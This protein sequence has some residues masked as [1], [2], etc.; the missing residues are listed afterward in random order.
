MDNCYNK[1][2]RIPRELM[3]NQDERL[4]NKH[5]QTLSFLQ[6]LAAEN[7]ALKQRVEEL[8]KEQEK[9]QELHA[10]AEESQNRIK[11]IQE[12]YLKRADDINQ[13]LSEQHRME[14]M[15]LLDDKMEMERELKEQILKLRHEIESL[16]R[17][18]VQLREEPDGDEEKQSFL[19]TITDLEKK[20]GECQSKVASL[21]AAR[22]E[23]QQA[24]SSAQNSQMSELHQVQDL[25]NTNQSLTDELHEEQQ[26]N[27][28]L[29]YKVQK[30]E[31][32]LRDNAA[33]KDQ[34]KLVE[35]MRN[36]MEKLVKE[37][38]LSVLREGDMS[39]ELADANSLIES[40]QKAIEE[41]KKEKEKVVT[42]YGELTIEFEK[43]RRRLL[44]DQDK[45]AFRDFVAVKR[46]LI[47][48]KNENEV[49]RLKV[50][51]SS[52]SLPMLKEDVP[53][54]KPPVVM[55]KKGR[56]KLLAISLA[57]GTGNSQTEQM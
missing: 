48:V 22:D 35:A 51:T 43:L 39:Q 57:H 27:L 25:R 4:T 1:S 28:E 6:D 40:L 13:M 16:Q 3:H 52:G 18:N 34:A 10:L 8:E 30:L 36:K 14:M 50:R 49:L 41:L 11:D 9:C 12:K 33:E 17:T 53:P 24:L 5:I 44:Q 32:E 46:E 38:E 55:S 56:K 2:S 21:T 20:L 23:L 19:N 45:A 47:S 26:K 7:K 29:A 37:K 42:E 54:P 15:Q 31:N